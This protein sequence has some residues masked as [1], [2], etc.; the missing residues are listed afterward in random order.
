MTGST[1][2]RR[3]SSELLVAE[4]VDPHIGVMSAETDNM[5]KADEVV[6]AA[7]ALGLDPSVIVWPDRR[8]DR[9]AGQPH[10]PDPKR[11]A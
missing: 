6:E 10:L 9:A 2:A 7:R 4:F 1:P 5:S 8:E 11:G 3:P